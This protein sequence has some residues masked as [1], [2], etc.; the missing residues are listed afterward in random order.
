VADQFQT[1]IYD[2]KKPKLLCTPVN[3]NFEGFQR[4]LAN[5][6]CFSVKTAKG[7]QKTVPVVGRI[8]TAN[9]LGTGSLDLLKEDLLCVPAT[10][11]P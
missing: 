10:R 8:V 2:V 9:Q 11:T 5:L 4:P 6:M 7:Q 1:R 3:E